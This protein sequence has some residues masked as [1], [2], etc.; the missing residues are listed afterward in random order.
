MRRIVTDPFRSVAS[1]K[2][3]GFPWDNPWFLL[4]RY[5]MRV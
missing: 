3:M 1:M 2:S 5:F 4:F